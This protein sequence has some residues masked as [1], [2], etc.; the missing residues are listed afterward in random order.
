LYG[1]SP[2]VDRSQSSGMGEST[3]QTRDRPGREAG[4]RRGANDDEGAHDAAGPLRAAGGTD[5]AVPLRYRR[6]VGRYFQRIADELG[7]K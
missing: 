1:D 5:A 7:D 2:L 6:Q 4:G 3:R